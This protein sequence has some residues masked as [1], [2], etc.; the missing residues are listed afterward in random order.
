MHLTYVLLIGMTQLPV[1]DSA[2]FK[3]ETQTAAIAA[4]VRV[5]DR[6]RDVAGSG[7]VLGIDKRGTYVLTAAHLVQRIEQ[8]EVQTF[9]A[10]SYPEPAESFA[11]VELVA[12]SSSLRDLAVLRLPP[13]TVPPTQ[14]RLAPAGHVPPK[15]PFTC[16]VVGCAASKPPKAH[17]DEVVAAKQARREPA[18]EPVLFWEIAAKQKGGQSGGPL[19][20]RDGLVLGICS[21]NNK[22]LSYFCHL[23]EIHAFLKAHHLEWLFEAKPKAKK[24]GGGIAPHALTPLRAS[25]ERGKSW[26]PC[27]LP[28][29]PLG[30]KG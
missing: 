2:D 26:P 7:V 16:L 15:T 17:V 9:T 21:G 28:S 30:G 22:A 29:S 20:D 14:L 23:D 11:K 24:P 6:D 8:I 10:K 13:S 3:A 12:K 1:V 25:G 4:T 5:R 19:V 27:W 18:D